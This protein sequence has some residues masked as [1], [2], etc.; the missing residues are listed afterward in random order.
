MQFVKFNPSRYAG[1]R[2]TGYVSPVRIYFPEL[3]K[4]KTTKSWACSA[5]YVSVEKIADVRWQ[6]GDKIAIGWDAES[7]SLGFERCRDGICTVCVNGQQKGRYKLHLMRAVTETLRSEWG[8]DPK[9]STTVDCELKIHGNL[10][11]V[12]RKPSE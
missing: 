6:P 10:V 11:I 7:K 1:P 2:S 5:L 4:S 9:A 8:V 12:S 3:K